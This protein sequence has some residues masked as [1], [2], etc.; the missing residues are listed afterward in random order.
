MWSLTSP[1]AKRIS[2][3]KKFRLFPQKDF[4]NNIRGK[5]DIPR[6]GCHQKRISYGSV[7]WRVRTACS[8]MHS[9]HTSRIGPG[10]GNSASVA[11]AKAQERLICRFVARAEGG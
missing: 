10:V 2:G 5:A 4:C 7:G 1:L 6:Q 8:R 9:F 3:S 11:G